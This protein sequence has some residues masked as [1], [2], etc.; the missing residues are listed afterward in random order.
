M[1]QQ[2]SKNR[3]T[4]ILKKDG[5]GVLKPKLELS[6]S[7]KSLEYQATSVGHSLPAYALIMI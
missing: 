2:D 4:E 6:S 1:P 7:P 3:A 5:E